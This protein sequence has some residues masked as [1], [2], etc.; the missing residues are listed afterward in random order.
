[1]ALLQIVEGP[2]AGKRF[3]LNQ[4]LV[5][6]GREDTCTYQILDDT[7]SRTHLQVLLKAGRHHAGDYRS[8]N[9]VF[10]NDRQI[11]QHTA[12]GDGDR[13]RIGQTTLIYVSNDGESVASV[14]ERKK[15]GEWAVDTVPRKH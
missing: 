5:S 12:L 13:I 8:S 11:L 2:D 3:P 4:D 14:A 7:V 6:F 15:K 10:V 1:M 9:G